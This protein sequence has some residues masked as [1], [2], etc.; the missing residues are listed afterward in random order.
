MSPRRGGESDKL[1]NRYE[2]SWTVH[3]ALFCLSS[4]DRSLTVEDI[5]PELNNGVEFSY[6]ELGKTQVHQLKRSTTNGNEWSVSALASQ[7]VFGAAEAHVAQ[8]REY[9][10]VSS[11]PC[12]NLQEL[13]DR[14]RKADDALQ[15]EQLWLTSKNL[16]DKF[17][18]LSSAPYFGTAAKAWETLRGM[19]FQVQTEIDVVRTNTV[20]AES[21]LQGATGHLMCLAVHD[22]LLDTMG[23]RI[24]RELLETRLREHG[25]VPLEAGTATSLTSAIATQTAAWLST[26]RAE[27]LRPVILRDEGPQL[28]E[29]LA[30]GRLCLVA[31]T[32]GGGKSAVLEQAVTTLQSAGSP[33]LALRLDRFESF[34]S[35]NE[36]GQ[37]LGLGT[38]PAA[39]LAVAAKG[40]DSYLVVDQLDAVSLA[41]GRMP[42]SFDVIRELIEEALTLQGVK[43]VLACREFD[44]ENDHRIRSL[45]A[46]DDLKK[47]TV[48]LLDDE[49]V[50]QA[51]TN[52]GLD[53]TKLT[54]SQRGLL[55]TPVHLV[56]LRTIADQDDALSFQSRGSLFEQFWNRK[57]Q[58]CDV[59]RPGVRFAAVIARVANAASDRQALSIP[60][61][62]LD[63]G[64]LRRDADVLVSEHVLARGGD[65][66]AFFHESFFDYAFA[67]L[68]VSRGQSLVEFL[69][70][71]E[72]E[73][74]RRGQV[75]Q[76]LHHLREREPER[77]V[78]ELEDL[79]ASD[80]IRFHLKEA[81]LAVLGA[82]LAPTSDELAVVL[83]LLNGEIEF[84]DRLW[85]QVSR[86]TWFMRFHDEGIVAEWLDS[87]AEAERIR[88][89]D[90][91]GSGAV[92][93]G[94]QVAEL[95]ASRRDDDEYFPRLR[96]VA[97]RA[98]L[99]ENRPIFDLVL[100]AVRVGGFD[101][102]E[103]E[104]WLSAHDLVQQNPS[105]AIELLS[106]RVVEHHDAFA[107]NER[108]QVS[109][110]TL[111]EYS[112]TELARVAGRREPLAFVKV[113]V[114]YLQRVVE[115][116]GSA[117]HEGRPVRDQHFML[118]FPEED[119][120]SDELD[121]VLLSA[122]K[123]ALE[124][125]ARA[126]PEEIRDVLESLAEDP[127]DTSQFL[128]YS[129]M[130]ANGEHYADWASSLLLEGG[131]RLKCGYASD[132]DWVARELVSAIAP[133]LPDDQH[134]RL[135]DMVRDMQVSYETRQSRGH[136]AFTFLSALDES[137][138]STVGRRRLGEYRRKFAADEPSPPR[139]IVG[140]SVDSP[141]SDDAASR[142]SDDQWLR[143][144]RRYDTDEHDWSTFKGGAHELSSVLRA[145]TAGDPDRFAVL[146]LRLTADINDSYGDAILMGLGDAVD[147]G[148]SE[149]AFAAIRHI[150]G[151]GKS[152][153]D[154]WLG[155]ALRQH[156]RDVPL[157]LV[158]LILERAMHSASPADDTPVVIQGDGDGR[159]AE[160]LLMNGINT[161]RGALAEALGD[162]LI[163]D[164]DGTR[165]ALVRPHLEHLASDPVLSVRSCVA[166]TLAASLRHA[167]EAVVPAF[168]VLIDADDVIL[169]ARLVLP[170][171]LY[172]GNVEPEVI[173]PVIE[174]MLASDN[175]EAREA[176]GQLAAHAALE[177]ERA[178]LMSRA[179]AAGDE[180]RVGIARICAA[181]FDRTSNPELA[182]ETL[183]ALMDDDHD[184]TREAVAQVAPNLRDQALRPFEALLKA[185]IAS[186][187]Y[188]EATPQLLLT[189]Q[190]A[191]DKVDELV[192]L[193]AQR[194]LAVFGSEAGDI[195]T[196]ASG[197]AH[198]ISELVVRGLAQSRNRSHRAALL[199][200][201]DEMLLLGVY[202]IGVAIEDAERL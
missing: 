108:G 171:M 91:V 181:R 98:H 51:V 122:C 161:S 119:H 199:D 2:A 129:A 120:R 110:L 54:Q 37:R 198:Y 140:G 47:I 141:I 100:E 15:F 159:R 182:Q 48:N 105:W 125:L 25:V 63:E 134:R 191:L 53:A 27:L 187:A 60:I 150:A 19:W 139:G 90:L 1:G 196:G 131:A 123:H 68:W 88:A 79:L 115:A 5:D 95:L 96:W 157:D 52:M 3:H 44:I 20:I 113:F 40:A 138:L 114:P 99:H 57:Q 197:D 34:A 116:T 127:Y 67:R 76:I 188:D 173:H 136:T 11:A 183:L 77:F 176:G 135:E 59:R 124:A 102:H 202:G 174:R 201:L 104:L 121:E 9:H 83:R 24:T 133:H 61:E 194:F 32:A 147:G 111:R 13:A 89:A 155:M 193:A 144:I 160:D 164:T 26:V 109:A 149:L 64:D 10:F 50:T 169:A 72:Q 178:E 82:L 69:T 33:V 17:T 55:K 66:V 168:R 154:R 158:Q 180:A 148:D 80:Q 18:E 177:W 130:I 94:D 189:L 172:I 74:F 78:D 128:L 7:N 170:L 87:G 126:Q 143:A 145:R 65:R 112:A 163:Y 73:L 85:Q 41:S 166:H 92:A 192:L 49:D 29:T 46:R 107:L 56:M 71:D 16:S 184:K 62:L 4:D 165:T 162:L 8:G 36:I 84:A 86:P 28:T 39:A 200:V 146:A 175:A 186:K 12:G 153:N 179:M 106:A 38:S 152:S 195:R 21:W 43:V 101:D 45:A 81:A 42:Q 97:R 103:E 23:Q 58:L 93:N 6:V 118:R 167:R 137:R 22:V 185:L 190:H 75:R 30:E 142:M 132:G 35:T 117:H 156:Y 31:G 151:F 70:R 14:A